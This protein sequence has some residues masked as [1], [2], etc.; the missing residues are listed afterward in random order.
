MYKLVEKLVGEFGEVLQT[1]KLGTSNELKELVNK[2]IVI[3]TEFQDCGYLTTTGQE[4]FTVKHEFYCNDEL[5]FETE[6]M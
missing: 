4:V 1:I 6:V 2:A 3:D 5:I